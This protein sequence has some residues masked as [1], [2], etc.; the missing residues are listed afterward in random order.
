MYLEVDNSHK[1][2]TR[3]VVTCYQILV[4][5]Y[6]S[7]TLFSTAEVC[8]PPVRQCICAV[9]ADGIGSERQ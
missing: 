9:S 1:P 3:V 6:K 8:L 5:S 4:Y 7:A 2:K